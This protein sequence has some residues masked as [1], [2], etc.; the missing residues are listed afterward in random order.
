M[1]ELTKKNHIF[2]WN[3]THQK[4]FE[5]IKKKLTQAP[6]MAYF[7]TAKRSLL[8]VDGSP[9]RI[10]AILAQRD[11]PSELYRVISYA[12]RALSPV[13]SR[14]SQTDIE[15]LS[16]VWGIEHF[17]LF[18]LGTEFDVYTDHKAL[19]AIFNNP[20]SKP[21]ARI[22]RWMLRLQPYNFRVIY[23]KGTVNEADY[24]SRHP[25]TNKPRTTVEERIA[26]NYVNFIINHTVPKSM[27]LQEIKDA[28]EIDTTLKTVQKCMK[29]GKWDEKDTEL[30]PYR[31][32]AE[33]LSVNQTGDLVL[34]GSKIVIPKALQDHA[35]KLGHEGHQGIEKT[36]SLLREKIWYPGMDDKV[37]KMIEN[38]VACQA[39]GPN[40]SPEPMRI[41]PTATEPWQSLAIDFYGPIPRSGQYLLV[42]IDTYSK[43]PEVE[44]VKSTSVKAC[45]PKL[46]R[47]FATHGIP[48]KIRTDNGPPFNGDEFK[49]YMEVLGIEWKT[50]TPL[51]PQANG[52]AESIMKPIG[53]VIK[54][55]TLEGKNWRQ[56]LQRFLL[57]YRS[58]PH[59]TMKIPPCELLFNRKIQG[60]LPELTTKEVIDKHKEAKENIDKRKKIN[61]KYYDVNTKASNI[62]E[63]DTV[64]CEQKPVNKLSPR[65]NPEKFTVIK[66]KGATV[67]AKNDRRTIT[68]NMSHFK[69]MKSAEE[70]S[71]NENQSG[72]T[73]HMGNEPELEEHETTLR[74]STREQRP[75]KRYGNTVTSELIS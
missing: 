53:K 45:I 37:K 33:E 14:Y 2:N 10:C 74:R 73:S 69:L 75:V 43:F 64:I 32:C 48:R 68:R 46:D 23:K 31:L 11:K 40:N 61:K 24:L 12:S 20:K 30:K 63:G 70:E 13:E 17:R 55:A 25:V 16:L 44:I 49:R 38:C 57:N 50:S 66:R 59:A 35:T 27:T 51:W 60:T 9:L 29:T 67:V 71:D 65:F 72:E 62:K 3:N 39:V 7:D 28:T 42:V 41:T 5:Q 26:D 15:G 22:E 6:T 36:K 18:L 54:T 56:E 19:E 1:R 8:I 21:P 34:K 47:I 58:T 4:A 52:N